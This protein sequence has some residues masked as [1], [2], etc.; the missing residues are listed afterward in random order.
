MKHRASLVLFIL[1]P[2]M[3]LIAISVLLFS[4]EGGRATQAPK[5]GLDMVPVGNSY[6][7]G[8]NSMTV[9]TIDNCLATDAP[10]NNDRHN[11]VVDLVVQDVEDL[12]G[13]QARVNY[14]GGKMRPASVNFTPFMDTATGQNISFLNL[15]IDSALGVHRDQ[16]TASNIPPPAPGPQTAGFGSAYVGS[17]DFPISPD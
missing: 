15:P 11:H 13:W 1:P 14:D 7:V 3:G 10:G 6:D 2:M 5:V 9:G 4:A 16:N 17:R 12:I 8:S